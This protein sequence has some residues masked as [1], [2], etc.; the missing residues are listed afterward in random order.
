MV[1]RASCSA[2][3]ATDKRQIHPVWLWVAFERGQPSPKQLLQPSQDA[4]VQTAE[5][6]EC[7]AQW[8]LGE[9]SDQQSESG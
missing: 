9:K 2:A 5:G 8:G 1:Q 6:G 7:G 4:P 3:V